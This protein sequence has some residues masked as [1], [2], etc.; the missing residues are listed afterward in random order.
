MLNDCAEISVFETYTNQ[1]S[2]RYLKDIMKIAKIDKK[3]T[4][5]CSRHTFATI[6]L[7]IGIPIEIVSQILEHSSVK[8]TEVYSKLWDKTKFEQMKKINKI[9]KDS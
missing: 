4:F 6:A 8:M 9:F 1:V 5:H 7:N 3:I 2:N